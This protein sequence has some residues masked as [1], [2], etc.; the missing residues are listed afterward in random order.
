MTDA[1]DDV[2]F[3]ARSEN[4]VAVLDSLREGPATRAALQDRLGIDR[5]TL[6]RIL[7]SFEDREW[8]GTDGERYAT[9]FLGDLVADRF[10]G[11]RSF[12][13]TARDLRALVGTVPLA[14]LG[15][16]VDRLAD[17][18]VTTA[19]EG[20]PYA[21]VRQFMECVRDSD[22][23]SGYDT[24]TIAP[25]YVDEIREEI[26]GGMTTEIVYRPPVIDQIVSDYREAVAG[27]VESG[28]LTLWVAE[29]LPC[30]L[31]I[32][33]DR[34]GIGA[35]DDETG[36]LEVFVESDDPAIREWATESFATVRE[37]AT[38]LSAWLDGPL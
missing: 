1:V 7:A 23:L 27:A 2:E 30:G 3:L 26:L 20:D 36:M 5:V 12:V 13:A 17:A 29:D 19:G 4:R 37:S 18:T 22:S 14:E 33:D 28:H 21:P 24:T 10:G 34:V 6:G 16:P 38:S 25:I 32:F 35:Y 31:A 9:T 11:F 8:V 15:F